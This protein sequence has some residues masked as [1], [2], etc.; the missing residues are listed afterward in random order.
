LRLSAGLALFLP[1]ADVASSSGPLLALRFFWPTAGLA[2][3][4][5]PAGL[6]LLLGPADLALLLGPADLALKA[7]AGL[8]LF[9]PLSASF[10]PCVL[11]S[12]QAVPFWAMVWIFLLDCSV[13]SL[14]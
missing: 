7:S 2:L 5:G 6:A 1:I 11:G 14:L 9:F 8:G 12:P 3:L 4:L 13:R 10:R